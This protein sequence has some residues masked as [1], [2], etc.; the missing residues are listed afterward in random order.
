MADDRILPSPQEIA[1]KAADALKADAEKGVSR[2]L[3][4]EPFITRGAEYYQQHADKM[5]RA[6]EAGGASSSTTEAVLADYY[7]ACTASYFLNDNEDFQATYEQMNEAIKAVSADEILYIDDAVAFLQVF[8]FYDLYVRVRRKYRSTAAAN[9]GEADV[10]KLFLYNQ[11]F[12]YEYARAVLYM[13]SMGELQ[14]S[15]LKATDAD[16]AQSYPMEKYPSWEDMKR[17]IMYYYCRFTAR[18]ALNGTSG[19]LASIPIPKTATI[20]GQLWNKK[21]NIQQWADD[22]GDGMSETLQKFNRDAGTGADMDMGER[23][24]S[25]YRLALPLQANANTIAAFVNRVPAEEG[26]ED[27]YYNFQTAAAQ[28]RQDSATTGYF[29]DG[30]VT[31]QSIRRVAEGLMLLVSQKL[32]TA[33]QTDPRWVN[34][35]AIGATEFTKICGYGDRPSGNQ[36]NQCLTTLSLF[37]AYRCVFHFRGEWHE[38]PI[39]SLRR[40]VKETEATNPAQVR[41]EIDVNSDMLKGGKPNTFDKLGYD[42]FRAHFRGG[43]KEVFFRLLA[44]KSNE[45]EEAIVKDIYDYDYNIKEAKK[46]DIMDGNKNKENL[47]A[48]KEYWRKNYAK[49]LHNVQNWYDEANNEGFIIADKHRGE[50][51]TIIYTWTKGKKTEPKNITEKNKPSKT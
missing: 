6:L 16:D 31:A 4:S 20:Q 45:E 17:L 40:H 12:P 14:P 37:D 23:D 35:D 1:E 34:L 13:A 47:T 25:K 49:F 48:Y 22:W 44:F 41:L 9:N 46:A 51:G 38:V 36:I 3:P 8:C 28:L 11:Q 29:R 30:I 7:T 18:F 27:Q 32:R 2:V 10:R 43:A 50:K 26:K 39:I 5:R 24:F 15:E 19:E 42:E 21:D 33:K